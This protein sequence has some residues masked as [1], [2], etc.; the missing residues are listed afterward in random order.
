MIDSRIANPVFGFTRT[1]GSNP[2]LSA[3]LIAALVTS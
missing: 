2:A 3:C 1:A